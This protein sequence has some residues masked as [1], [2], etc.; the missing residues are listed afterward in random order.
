MC[1]A[2]ITVDPPKSRIDT[3]PALLFFTRGYAMNTALSKVNNLRRHLMAGT[4][5][6]WQR[7]IKAPGNAEGVIF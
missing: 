7:A 1:G 6:C 4:V 2:S 5:A 3:P